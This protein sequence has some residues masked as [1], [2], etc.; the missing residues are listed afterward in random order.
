MYTQHIHTHTQ[1]LSKSIP[2]QENWY[3]IA[4]KENNLQKERETTSSILQK[5]FGLLKI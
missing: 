1:I 5:F 2:S 3:Q 4:I